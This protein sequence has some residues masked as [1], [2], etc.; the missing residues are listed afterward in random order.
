ME[1]VPQNLIRVPQFICA[2]QAKTF[3]NQNE[4]FVRSFVLMLERKI[5]TVETLILSAILILLVAVAFAAAQDIESDP[6][7][8][9]C[10]VTEDVVQF[11]HPTYCNHFYKCVA[12]GGAKDIKCPPGLAYNIGRRVCDWK[13]DVDCTGRPQED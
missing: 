13:C 9:E 4:R 8:I 7:C 10:G 6:R 5:L 12:G 11:E 2:K 1:L 3:T